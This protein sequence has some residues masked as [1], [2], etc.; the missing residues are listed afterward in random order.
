[1]NVEKILHRL[2][3]LCR[4]GDICEIKHCVN[5]L[6]NMNAVFD[7]SHDDGILG[8]FA[9]MY[10]N[11]DVLEFLFG[12]SN[13]IKKFCDDMLDVAALNGYVACVEFLLN[14]GA[15]P[16]KLI[17]T[18]S[19]NN[20]DNIREIFDNCLDGKKRQLCTTGQCI[21]CSCDILTSNDKNIELNVISKIET[22]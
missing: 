1:M 8:I 22:Y 14:N 2:E 7:L 10:G 16:A 4:C 13:S 11:V 6:E 18:T 19:Y 12:K 17:D 15:N 20:Y 21:H 5:S 3:Y 9:A